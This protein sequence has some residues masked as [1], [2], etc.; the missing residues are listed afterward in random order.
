MSY[1][2][3]IEGSLT[4]GDGGPRKVLVYDIEEKPPL[5]STLALR[6]LEA[7]REKPRYPRALARILGLEEQT[8]YY[9]I[10]RLEGLGL[11][12][13]AGSRSVR[14]ATATL[15]STSYDGY[16]QLFA[17]EAGAVEPRGAGPGEALAMFFREF[18]AGG[19]IDAQI[20][21]GSPEPHGPYRAA[22]RDGHYAVQLALTLGSLARPPDSFIVKLDVDVRAEGTY[23][24]NTLVIGGPGT[25]LLAAELNPSLPVRFDERNYWMGLLDDEGRVFNDPSDAVVAK[26]VN[27]FSP[28]HYI[29]LAA[30]VRHVGTKAAVLALS[31]FHE[32]VLRRYRGLVPFAVVVRGYDQDGDGK[33]DSVEPLRYYE[34]FPGREKS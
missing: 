9:H 3:R 19:V 23:G 21:V 6:I 10:R 31:V 24:D 5:E 16:A 20:V 33:V 26:M 12:E 15:Y 2:G 32:S 28:G 8:V 13:R 14:G 22:A 4:V 30:G 1:M 18:I 7:L 25:N 11:V 17:R 27:P 29:V 34:G